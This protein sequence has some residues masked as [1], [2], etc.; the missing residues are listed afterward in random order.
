MR[1]KL[2][3]KK[4]LLLTLIIA[5][6]LFLFAPQFSQ[7]KI[8]NDS[9]QV[10]YNDNLSD[11]TGEFSDVGLPENNLEKSISI[12]IRIALTITGT[13]FVFLMVIA[14]I[15]WM[16]ANGNEERIKKSKDTITNLLIGLC[17]IVAAY[18]LSS[19]IST[20]LANIIIT[21]Q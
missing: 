8:F 9:G 20:M 5:T 19:F 17:L 11:I 12:I 15:N 2:K 14:G 7:A 3:S 1:I 13:I 18:A 6:L 21:R 4:I 10:K 16:R